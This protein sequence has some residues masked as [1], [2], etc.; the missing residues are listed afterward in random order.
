M[1]LT[2]ILFN[3]F[4]AYKIVAKSNKSTVFLVLILAS[5]WFLNYFLH[6]VLFIISDN[7]DIATSVND[8]R[9][10]HDSAQFNN[11]LAQCFL[12][13]L[14][15]CA[16]L[17][18][19]FRK[20]SNLVDM[21]K[22]EISPKMDLYIINVGILVGIASL[23]IENTD[24]RNPVTKSLAAS[25]ATFFSVF[26]WKQDFAIKSK[27]QK[28]FTYVLGIFSLLITSSLL[29]NSKGVLLLPAAIF[30]YRKWSSIS[31][32]AR[33]LK[34][35]F[36]LPLIIFGIIFFNFLQ[37]RKLGQ[38]AILHTTRFGDS[39]P[40]NL[41]FLLPISERFDQFA[42]LIDAN[43]AGV[44]ALGGYFDWLVYFIRSLIWNPST[45]RVESGFG[46]LWNSEITNLS[47]KGAIKSDVSFAP[48][49]IAE[50]YI[51]DGFYSLII[52]CSL[53]AVVFFIVANLLQRGILSCILGMGIIGNGTLFEAGIISFGYKLTESFKIFLFTLIIFIFLHSQNR[54]K[55]G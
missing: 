42:R 40:W 23:F 27:A 33:F 18:L 28:Y 54:Y 35:F 26:L 2:A 48:G 46:E 37:A 4:L 32:P 6:P 41:D 45:G 55:S 51:W 36:V 29:G 24:L 20:P 52:G 13:T 25:S 34:S 8:M 44:G 53:M 43:I 31:Q 14:V 9:I 47:I 7:L 17:H 30:I 39:L 1:L 16:T 10:D 21:Y 5:Y 22:S 38:S 50:S 19:F 11:L 15:F 3:C 49:M 12:G